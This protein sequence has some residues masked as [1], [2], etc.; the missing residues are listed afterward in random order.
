MND[1]SSLSNN[2]LKQLFCMTDNV[3]N[4]K[5]DIMN[6]VKQFVMGITLLSLPGLMSAC[7]TVLPRG[8]VRDVVVARPGDTIHLF[9]GGSKQARQEFC[10]DAVVPVYRYKNPFVDS[11]IEAGKIKITKGLGEHYI[12]GVVVEGMIMT[13]DIAVQ[14]TSE[15][16][17]RLP[18]PAEK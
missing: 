16:L 13:G 14:P 9:Y 7:T 8:Q 12:E 18:E 10:L 3:T 15:C 2:Y 5:G 17:V 1:N 4:G 6:R 11:K